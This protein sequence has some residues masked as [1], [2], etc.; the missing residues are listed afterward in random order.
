[1]ML[2]IRIGDYVEVDVGLKLSAI[3][4]VITEHALPLFNNEPQ[5]TQTYKIKFLDGST[6]TA[7]SKECRKLTGKELFKAKLSADA[8]LYTR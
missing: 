3:G 6:H 1:M 5:Y 4:R 7:Y 8:R 2:T